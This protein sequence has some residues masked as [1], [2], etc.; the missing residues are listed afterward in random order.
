MGSSQESSIMGKA[1][2]TKAEVCTNTGHW[3]RVVQVWVG[4]GISASLS[5]LWASR[6]SQDHSLQPISLPFPLVIRSWL[7]LAA[8][9]SGM[10][11]SAMICS[12]LQP[13][14]LESKYQI[15]SAGVKEAS[16]FLCNCQPWLISSSPCSDGRCW[17]YDSPPV[18]FP[19]PHW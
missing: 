5:S 11:Y 13:E 14:Q 1:T 19:H 2:Q 4:F 12:V 3:V 10:H 9:D 8:D 16:G 18:F 17:H 15:R 7:L 6:G